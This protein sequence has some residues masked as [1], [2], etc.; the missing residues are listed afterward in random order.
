MGVGGNAR[1]KQCAPGARQ[2]KRAAT[3]PAWGMRRDPWAAS[4]HLGKLQ[5]LAPVLPVAP[6]VTGL[7]NLQVEWLVAENQATHWGFHFHCSVYVRDVPWIRQRRVAQVIVGQ[8]NCALCALQLKLWH[9]HFSFVFVRTCVM[10]VGVHRAE[11]AC[12]RP[13]RL[14]H[15]NHYLAMLAPC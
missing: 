13:M 12:E 5:A 9:C 1:R 2:K 10:L 3:H 15:R 6:S 8:S 4:G 11:R 7:P 14:S